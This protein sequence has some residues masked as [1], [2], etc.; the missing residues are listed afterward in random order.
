MDAL[1]V[2]QH[3]S[4]RGGPSQPDAPVTRCD[5]A[6]VCGRMLVHKAEFATLRSELQLLEKVVTA[7]ARP[8]LVC[9]T[10][11]TCSTTSRASLARQGPAREVL[12]GRWRTPKLEVRLRPQHLRKTRL[13]ERRPVTSRLKGGCVN[14]SCPMPHAPR[15]RLTGI[16]SQHGRTRDIP[17][18][19]GQAAASRAW[20]QL[21]LA[22]LN[23]IPLRAAQPCSAA[24]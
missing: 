15:P 11:C 13:E 9:A 24:L 19:S 18:C 14:A 23:G 1:R 5:S 2:R 21:H 22:G 16:P 3:A 6:C 17:R 8:C 20:L 4:G 12:G 7:I 10:S